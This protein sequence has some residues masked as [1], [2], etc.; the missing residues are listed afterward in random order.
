[1]YESI[2]CTYDEDTEIAKFE[3]I[4]LD[5]HATAFA[6]KY[7]TVP[8]TKVVNSFFFHHLLIH[9][10]GYRTRLLVCQADFLSCD[11]DQGNRLGVSSEIV[12]I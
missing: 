12:F 3:Y 4:D 1:M 7:N 5:Y 11:A 2:K 10:P 8:Y 9:H 6:S